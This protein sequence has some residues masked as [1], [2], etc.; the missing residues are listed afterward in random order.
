[1]NRILTALAIVLVLAAVI[2][3][4]CVT[5]AYYHQVGTRSEPAETVSAVCPVMGTAIADVNK[6]AGKS[7]YK[8]KAYYFC[9][10]GCKP[11]FDKNPEKYV[12]K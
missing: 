3:G 2:V 10:P 1:M 9:C 4:V 7:I 11:E 8:G 5:R 6:A 12:G